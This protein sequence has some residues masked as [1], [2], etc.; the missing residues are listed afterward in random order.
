MSRHPMTL[1]VYDFIYIYGP[2]NTLRTR[3]PTN[4]TLIPR[5]LI[6]AFRAP[7]AVPGSPVH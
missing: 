5:D 7:S 6:V 4:R 2:R 1:Q 3:L